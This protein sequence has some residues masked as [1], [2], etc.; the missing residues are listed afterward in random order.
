MQTSKKTDFTKYRGSIDILSGGFPCQPFSVAGHTRG[1]ADD[2]YLWPEM[3]RAIREIRPHYVVGE[4]VRGLVSWS[5]GLV[6][7][8]AQ[9]DLEAE[10]YKVIPFL[11]P[12][13]GVNA[14]HK[15]YRIW[16]I[17]H[18][19][20]ARVEGVQG[21]QDSADRPGFVTNTSSTGLQGCRDTGIHGPQEHTG[22]ERPRA[23]GATAHTNG[24]RQPTEKLGET[25]AGRY[26]AEM[27]GFPADWTELPFQNGETSL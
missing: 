8:T 14:P 19:T 21:P 9:S 2:R 10:G 17:A 27:M 13:C 20:D 24:R 26:L 16:F 4:N 6:F 11:L 18:T 7:D 5:D 12:A 23:V 25:F 1:T 22:P 3:L 15:R